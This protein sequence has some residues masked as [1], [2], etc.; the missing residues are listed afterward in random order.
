MFDI[1][2]YIKDFWLIDNSAVI[3]E[4]Q[5][6][7]DQM[8][9]HTR[10]KVPSELLLSQRPNE[11]DHIYNYRIWNYRAITYG[12][13]NRALD[14]VSRILNKIQ[15][16]IKCEDN[17]RKY[18]DSK[19]FAA[20]GSQYDFQTYFE[21]IILKRDIEDP[22]GFI[23]WLPTG[24]GLTNS[25]K[26]VNPKPIL[27]YSHQLY[28][29]TEDVITFLSDEKSPISRGGKVVL[30]G[31]VYY[32]ITK[33]TFYKL[34]Q[35]S[36]SVDATATMTARKARFRLDL[37]YK[38]NIGEIPV[39]VL[40]G[41]MNADGYFESYFAPYCAFGDEAI[42]TFSDFQ[43]IKVTSG[44]PYREEFYTE[45]EVREI[46]DGREN[47]GNARNPNPKDE[48]YKKPEKKLA[49][50][51]QTP[52]NA[53]IRTIAP[54]KNS[55]IA[56]N[57]GE[58]VLPN[59]IPSIRFISPDINV[60]KYIGEVWEKLIEK[61]EDALHLNLGINNSNVAD[62]TVQTQKEE[63]YAM[64][65]KISN[66]YFNHLMINSIKY[67]DCYLN[68]RTIDVAV[69]AINRPSSSIVKTE[70][71]LINEL[72]SLTASNV[73]PVFL[74]E[75]VNE[76]GLKRFSGNPLSQKIFSIIPIIDP[77]YVYGISQKLQMVNSGGITSD[78]YV[79]SIYAYP[80]LLQI[81]NEKTAD[82]F[83]NLTPEQIVPL[84]D[85]KLKPYLIAPVQAFDANGNPI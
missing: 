40:G 12:S 49:K 84:F 44:Y 10:K 53:I 9:V 26:A 48:K 43:A 82:V 41:D 25:A 20:Q 2:L 34:V 59:D 66:N 64:I 21:K 71:D 70:E 77:L 29:A 7:F 33:D 1:K 15:Y 74:A 32:L 85:E 35:I 72:T 79:R 13:M 36:D 69:C 75:T 30:A 5:K 80:I 67:I 54:D 55:K 60:L 16:T 24:E 47:M 4:W 17:V 58:R 68:R 65:E 45:C 81:A 31:D 22:N 46:N 23:A 8:A 19:Q 76:L 83:Q 3:R 18:L 62:K 42:V 39:L 73:P 6:I 56:Q 51:P 11:E 14:S 28:D 61:A 38:H 37:I 52:Y 50:F 57:L 78:A 63:H 27:F